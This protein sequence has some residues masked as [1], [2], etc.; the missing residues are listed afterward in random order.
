MAGRVEMEEFQFYQ[1]KK[2]RWCWRH[3]DSGG[4]ALAHS[5]DCYQTLAECVNDAKRNGYLTGPIKWRRKTAPRVGVAM[6]R[7]RLDGP[8]LSRGL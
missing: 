8:A 7:P 4:V 2:H 1:D 5:S 6:L 3:V